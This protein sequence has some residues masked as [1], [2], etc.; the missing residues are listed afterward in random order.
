MYLCVKFVLKNLNSD[1]YFSHNDIV[2]NLSLRGLYIYLYE[3]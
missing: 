2:K 1:P 3:M